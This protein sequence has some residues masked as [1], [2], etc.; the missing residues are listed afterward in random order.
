M[1]TPEVYVH[2]AL[3]AI[4]VEESRM[5]ALP[6]VPRLVHLLT[7]RSLAARGLTVELPGV[8]LYTAC[9]PWPVCSGSSWL[10][11]LILGWSASW[12]VP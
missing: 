8:A 9:G 1:C 11:G 10:C 2:S 4:V 6:A 12:L 3:G 5:N 7:V